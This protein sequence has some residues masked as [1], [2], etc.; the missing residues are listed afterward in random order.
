MLS[1]YLA[2]LCGN[3]ARTLSQFI[4]LYNVQTVNEWTKKSWKITSKI[5]TCIQTENNYQLNVC[6]N[7]N[8]ACVEILYIWSICFTLKMQITFCSTL[9]KDLVSSMLR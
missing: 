9:T 8:V 4:W 7:T 5:K 2:T 1:G 6:R 3:T